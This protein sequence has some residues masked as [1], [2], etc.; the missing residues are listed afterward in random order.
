MRLGGTCD[1]KARIGAADQ[2][3]EW[4]CSEPLDVAPPPAL[5]VYHPTLGPVACPLL[6][7]PAPLTL[8]GS[9]DGRGSLRTATAAVGDAG[10]SGIRGHAWIVGADQL[11]EVRV[12]SRVQGSVGPPLVPGLLRLSERLAMDLEGVSQLA[13]SYRAFGLPNTL[14]AAEARDLLW[15]I[16]YRSYTGA[17]TEL[18][19]RVQSGLLQVVRQPFATGATSRDVSEHVRLLGASSGAD[20]HGWDAALDAGESHVIRWLRAELAEIGLTEDDVPAP[21]SLRHP[22]IMLAASYALIHLEDV[23]TRL[24]EQAEAALGVAKKRIWVDANRDG[25]PDPSEIGP[26]GGLRSRD[27]RSAAPVDRRFRVGMSH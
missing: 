2:V 7:N 8:A 13:W 20:S 4:V 19:P 23:S 14:V 25:T 12:V 5:V 22:A 9:T 17:D 10:V 11:V 26:V 3:L 21:Q 27:W 24:R 6:T 18:L 1:A 16:S 15:E